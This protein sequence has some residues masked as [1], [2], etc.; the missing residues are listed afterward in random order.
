MI[1]PG[2]LIISSP[3]GDRPLPDR[4]VE[5][6]TPGFDWTHTYASGACG[7]DIRQTQVVTERF[8]HAGRYERARNVGPFGPA[9]V[10]L[11]QRDGDELRIWGLGLY[12][13]SSSAEVPAGPGAPSVNLTLT[14]DGEALATG[15]DPTSFTATLPPG[16]AA[17]RLTADTQRDVPWTDL[18]TRQHVTWDFSSEHTDSATLPLLVVRYRMALD[19]Q[20]RAPGGADQHFEVRVERPGG[21]VA[22]DVTKPTVD[23]SFDDGTT[24]QPVMFTRTGDH[25]TATLR[26]AADAQHVS[27][28]ARAADT[29]GNSVDQTLIHAYGITR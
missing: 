4:R 15:T 11:N 25:W 24:W 23:A 12:A 2:G 27:L 10:A 8:D 21:A 20:N 28:R 7:S 1:W 22:T 16:R 6:V 3:A 29:T 14:H 18:S 26:N 13:E 19:E 17:Y 5:Y 9:L